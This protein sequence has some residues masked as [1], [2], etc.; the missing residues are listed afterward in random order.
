MSDVDITNQALIVEN[1]AAYA[2]LR[3]T[4]SGSTIPENVVYWYSVKNGKGQPYRDNPDNESAIIICLAELISS[5]K[6]KA[7]NA[8]SNALLY[9]MEKKYFT[10]AGVIE[11]LKGIATNQA[12]KRLNAIRPFVVVDTR[13]NGQD[14]R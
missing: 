4:E 6:T 9:E 5:E 11:H 3:A 12:V 14:G 1:N 13:H 10:A 8:L 2:S 7:L